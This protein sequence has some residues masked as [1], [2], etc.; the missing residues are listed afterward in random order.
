ML[1]LSAVPANV[2]LALA[3]SITAGVR[4]R[5]RGGA[6]AFHFAGGPGLAI[7]TVQNEGEGQIESLAPAG[8]SL[9]EMF[10]SATAAKQGVRS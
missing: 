9:T 2:L 8:R 6:A 3:S 4:W 7:E 1:T 5:Q 10:L